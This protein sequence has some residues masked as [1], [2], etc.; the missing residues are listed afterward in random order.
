LR[1]AARWTDRTD[2]AFGSR[3]TLWTLLAD[4]ALGSGLAAL[5]LGADRADRTERPGLA[6]E[7]G[8]AFSAWLAIVPVRA[9]LALRPL[10]AAFALGAFVPL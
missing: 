4:G 6:H 2:F 7:P 5:A 1:R 10:G 3:W 8:C 9:G